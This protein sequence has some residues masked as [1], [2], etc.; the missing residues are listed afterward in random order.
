MFDFLLALRA[1][2]INHGLCD[3]ASI[4]DQG[5]GAGLIGPGGVPRRRLVLGFLSEL[6]DFVPR[7]AWLKKKKK[8]R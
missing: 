1:A 6:Q 8:K 4:L 3:G 2:R 7:P 5:S